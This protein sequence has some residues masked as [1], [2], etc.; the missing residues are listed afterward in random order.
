M[1]AESVPN[2]IVTFCKKCGAQLR[3]PANLAGKRGKCAKCG[4]AIRIPLKSEA[5]PPPAP[6]AADQQAAQEK[7]P[8]EKP[9]RKS[10]NMVLVALVAAVVG[11]G[12]GLGIYA[13][14]LM[15][16]S[17]SI[18]P[19]PPVPQVP[20]THPE[21]AGTS[22]QPVSPPGEPSVPSVIDLSP[23]APPPTKRTAPRSGT[24]PTAKPPAP[25]EPKPRSGFLAPHRGP[26]RPGYARQVEVWD[27][28]HQG[29]VSLTVTVYANKTVEIKAK[30]EIGV[31]LV[32]VIKK[33]VRPFAASQGAQ[34]SVQADR[35]VFLDLQ[36]NPEAAVTLPL[37]G[38][39]SPKTFTIAAEKRPPEQP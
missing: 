20:Q 23:N 36:S 3:A 18:L 24:S 15:G 29:L 30:R 32:I 38:E 25:P 5:P 11:I 1:P 31:P 37:A 6:G 10:V 4:A 35:D 17:G 39:A 28:I 26:S 12:L 9:E 22:G 14:F 21:G 7:K 34:A 16:P 19:S 8:D 27:A 2:A 13:L 33:G